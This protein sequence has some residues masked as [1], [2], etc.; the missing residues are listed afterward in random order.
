M[1]QIEWAKIDTDGITMDTSYVALVS[2]GYPIEDIFFYGSSKL[3]C[4]D[5]QE[6][7]YALI[8][9]LLYYLILL[10]RAWKISL[11]LYIL[12]GQ[13]EFKLY[14][15]KLIK[16]SRQWHCSAHLDVRVGRVDCVR[17][18]RGAALFVGLTASAHEP[19]AGRNS[20]RK[21]WTVAAGLG[22][23]RWRQKSNLYKIKIDQIFSALANC[24]AHLDA[25]ELFVS[26]ACDVAERLLCS[27]ALLPVLVSPRQGRRGEK[28]STGKTRLG[29]IRQ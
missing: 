11:V 2:P 8:H 3:R 15:S 13:E 21:S 5:Y 17:R 1:W 10:S 28:N 20:V 25:A 12:S 26:A 23:I 16:S 4:I 24:S 27:S 7:T 6:Q 22:E 14:K 9:V 18:S 19:T 29:E